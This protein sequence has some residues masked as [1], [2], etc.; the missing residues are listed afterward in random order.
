MIRTATGEGNTQRRHP[1]ELMTLT[2]VGRLGDI[3]QGNN[4]TSADT[5]NMTK[6]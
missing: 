6:N 4:G 1:W 3:M 2:T 5:N